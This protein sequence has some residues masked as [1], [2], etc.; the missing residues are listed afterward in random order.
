[1]FFLNN[2][3]TFLARWLHCK[4]K[5]ENCWGST[6]IVVTYSL[7]TKWLIVKHL[8]A[9]HA[10]SKLYPQGVEL[11]GATD[12]GFPMCS[13]AHAVISF[14]ESYQFLNAVPPEGTKVTSIQCCFLSWPITWR[15]F[16][17]LSVS[18]DDIMGNKW[19]ETRRLNT[20]PYFET[21]THKSNNN[22]KSS[23]LCYT[24]QNYPRS[25]MNTFVV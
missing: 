14:K 18:F 24:A 21:T 11:A 16:N 9:A 19:C 12:N 2:N 20:C 1:M 17:T 3:T 8:K 7:N 23:S 4:L 10:V 5:K 22:K 25:W 15:D 13:P 6:F